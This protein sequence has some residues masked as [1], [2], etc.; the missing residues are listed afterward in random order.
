MPAKKHVAARARCILPRVE[1]AGTRPLTLSSIPV[2]QVRAELQHASGNRVVEGETITIGTATNNSVVL[3][4]PE[5]SRFHVELKAAKSGVEVHDLGSTNGTWC[6]GLRIARAIVPIGSILELGPNA[7]VQVLDGS[8]GETQVHSKNALAAVVGATPTMRKLMA[9]LQLAAVTDTAS[10]VMG[11]SGTGKELIARAIHD[12][13]ARA[14][15]PFVVIDCGALNNALISS[16]LFGHEKG[17]FTG[18]SDRRAGAFEQANGGTVFLDE[19]GELPLELQPNLLHAL[20][21]KAARRVGGTEDIPFD[22]RI[23]SATNRDLR[24]FVNEGR[25]R[26]DLYYRLA[27]IT[28]EVPPLRERPSDVP[29]LIE[30]FL[31]EFTKAKAHPAFNA[32]RLQELSS[33]AWRG[34]V[35]ELRNVV[36]ATLAGEEDEASEESTTADALEDLGSWFEEL[37]NKPFKE[38]RAALLSEVER[39]YLVST[40]ANANGNSRRASK[41]SGLERSQY[42]ALLR[43]HGIESLEIE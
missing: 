40:L 23:V 31:Y 36:E 1:H 34:N 32:A 28:F 38:A 17:A 12:L 29:L 39:R 41:I 42:R 19:I 5:I 11:E 2:L 15:K 25:F 10:L 43:K 27:P 30:H 20:D 13:S 8:L 9:R 14:G 6:N 33:R 18:A 16:E 26:M 3:D 37:S 21:R 4:A 7:K 24:Q 22:V 35:R